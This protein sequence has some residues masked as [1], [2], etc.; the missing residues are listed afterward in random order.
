VSLNEKLAL[1]ELLGFVGELVIVGAGGV[2]PARTSTPMAVA[3]FVVVVHEPPIPPLDQFTRWFVSIPVAIVRLSSL[4]SV[5]EFAAAMFSATAWFTPTTKVSF[6]LASA[7]G[8]TVTVV[9]FAARAPDFTFV[10]TYGVVGSIP[11]VNSTALYALAEVGVAL[12]VIVTV[13][14]PEHEVPTTNVIRRRLFCEIWFA[15]VDHE[16]TPETLETVG[17]AVALLT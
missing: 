8:V 2:S 11:P 4:I 12:G 7:F 6:E 17:G 5:A 15:S 14:E 16:H 3:W 13:P 1:A 10:D 9:A